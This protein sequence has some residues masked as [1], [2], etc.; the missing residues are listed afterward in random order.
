VA[1]GS[2][3]LAKTGKFGDLRRRLV[4]L[5]L[6]LVVYRIPLEFWE[7]TGWVWLFVALALL[8]GAFFAFDLGQYLSLSALQAQRGELGGGERACLGY[9]LLDAPHQPIGGGMQDQP[10]LVC[11]GRSA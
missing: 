5:L 6:A 9:R 2:T 8:I 1:T 10:H 7:E 3:S 11:V 4:F